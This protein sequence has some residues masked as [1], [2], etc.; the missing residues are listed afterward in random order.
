VNDSENQEGGSARD[1]QDDLLQRV[2]ESFASAWQSNL[3]PRLEDYLSQ[4]PESTRAV[5]LERLLRVEIEFLRAGHHHL[6]LESYLQ[7]FP[8]DRQL[9]ESLF[10]ELVGFSG[11]GFSDPTPTVTSRPNSTD[12]SAGPTERATGEDSGSMPEQIGPYTIVSVLG[13]GGFGRV[14]RALDTQLQR[15]VAIKGPSPRYWSR[16]KRSLDARFHAEGA[17][18]IIGEFLEEA[19]KAAGLKHPGLVAVHDFRIEDGCPYIV[20]ELIEGSDLSQWIKANSAD[21]RQIVSMMIE[22][23][24][25]VAHA[26]QQGFV[27]RDLKPSNVL[28]DEHGHIHITDFGLALHESVQIERTTGMSGTLPYMSPEQLRCETH[29]LDGRS[30]LWSIG[31]M[32]YEL[33]AGRRPFVGSKQELM[34]QIETYDPRPPRQRRPELPAELERICL[35]CLEKRQSDRYQSA[36]ALIDDLRAWRDD[37]E[38]RAKPDSSSGSDFD[39]RTASGTESPEPELSIVP[40]GLRSFDAHD[41]DFFLKLLPGPRNR[42]GLPDSVQFWKTR[43]EERDGDQTFAVGLLYGPSG[44]GKS[45]LVQAGLL[46]RLD[47]HVAPVYVESTPDDTELRLLKQL[48]KRIPDLPATNLTETM[49]LLR[50]RYQGQAQKLLIVLDQFEQWLHAHSSEESRLLVDALRHCDGGTL[51][52]LVIVRDDFWMAATRFMRELDARLVEGVNSNAVDLFPI[53]HAEEVL[54]RFG[55]AYTAL[56]AGGELSPEQ[57]EFIQQA[58]GGLAQ[59]GQVICVRLALFAEMMKDK[60]WTPASLRD[61]GGT[62]GV[63]GAFLEETF[64]APSAPPEHRLHQKAARSV[65]RA[66]LPEAGTDIR[67]HMLPQETLLEASGYAHRPHDFTALLHILDNQLRLITPTDPEGVD[68]D[69]DQPVRASTPKKYFQLTHDFLVHA[70]RVWLTR[71][72]ME[73]RTGR[74]ELLLAETAEQWDATR[75]TKLLPSLPETLQIVLR[76]RAADWTRTQRDMIHTAGRRH[77]ARTGVF[78]VGAAILVAVLAWGRAQLAEFQRAR[79]TDAAVQALFDAGSEKVIDYVEQLQP[80]RDL[81]QDEFLKIAEDPDASLSERLRALLTLTRGDDAHATRLIALA[82]TAG[83]GDVDL[84]RRRLSS[85][86]TLDASE[87]W[88]CVAECEDMPAATLRAACLLAVGELPAVDWQKSADA[89]V[90]GLVAEGPV[91]TEAWCTL[92]GPDAAATI[93]VCCDQFFN[94]SATS[95]ERVI[96]AQAIANLAD[97]TT[98][99]DALLEADAEQF[100]YLIDSAAQHRA[101]IVPHLQDVIA[102]GDL[103]EE[104]AVENPDARHTELRKR[105]NAAVALVQLNEGDNVWGLLK[106][107]SDPTLRTMFM[108]TMRDFGVPLATLLTAVKHESDPTIR[109]ALWLA[110][111]SYSPERVAPSL[112]QS[113]T[114]LASDVV[115]SAPSQAERS[116]A[117]RLLK[118]WK[119]GDAVIAASTPRP[120]R[121]GCDWTI[122]SQGQVMVMIQG[123]IEFEMGA[124]LGEPGREHLE[125]LHTQ[126]ID[127]S[128][129]VSE[130]EVTRAQMHRSGG[131]VTYV[132]SVSDSPDCPINSVTLL[133]AI[134]YCRWLSEQENVPDEEMCYPPLDE[135]NE[136]LVLPPDFLNR[137]GYRLLT[138]PEWEFACR[139]HTRSPR[140]CGW[141]EAT[142]V[143]FG[144]FA[145]NS[146]ERMWPVGSLLP[147][148]FGL[149]DMHGNALEWCH[150]DVWTPSE[151]PTIQGVPRPSPGDPLSASTHPLRGGHYRSTPFMMRS[152]QRYFG[153]VTQFYSFTGFRIARTVRSAKP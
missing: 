7:R 8:A 85:L 20:Q 69:D 115:Q 128:F 116:G 108:L 134:R 151:A 5:A 80:D 28:V 131:D 144:W 11:N 150:N 107:R 106:I 92:L 74:A 97:A 111:A 149:F 57:G 10:H 33:L 36:A 127:H 124:P 25:A 34:L 139:A 60:S 73:T 43:M 24:E 18:R 6:K 101:A 54:T 99:A 1:E 129:E 65:L 103:P 112:A 26:H 21:A 95:S 98:L 121:P 75:K 3:S 76:T 82:L 38:P 90:L 17:E 122:N 102:G 39:K 4:V 19:R 142:L 9:V 70:L 62:E 77:A 118:S 31:V 37:V 94:P 147:N 141:D 84:I 16:L 52:C 117:E 114:D 126:S 91:K 41:A 153:N 125:T 53:R 119:R 136:N 110:M 130:Y 87:V 32:M 47:D 64:S 96:A 113:V 58:V 88:N 29:R 44:C 105:R 137:T 61:V 55:R 71:K 123:P 50:E 49:Q 13:L 35:K 63:G 146:K 143:N 22:V 135:I 12:A 46:P 93:T 140:S 100:P 48:R 79:R 81:W 27:H 89:I 104:S 59:D 78:F 30:D 40:R 42:F 138:E 15:P 14:Y 120:R 109:Q 56:P 2:S 145:S 152:A 133:Q 23:C 132:E 66:L 83:P 45:S 86:A 51:Q 72:Q 148:A 67:G 68:Q